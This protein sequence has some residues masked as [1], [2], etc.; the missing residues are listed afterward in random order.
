M[1]YDLIIIGGA[2]GSGK[3]TVQDIVA[4]KLSNV[5]ID[6]GN[7]REFHLDRYWKKANDK[8]ELMAF[9]N[10]VFIIKNYLKNK[11]INIMVNDLKYDKVIKLMRSFSKKKI[12]LIILTSEENELKKRIT[13]P[14]NSGFKNVKKALEYN[15]QWKDCNLKNSIKIDNSHNN[16]KKTAQKII[17][18]IN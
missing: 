5:C 1:A 7:L 18:I 11:Y 12:I 14:R 2:P 17:S 15:K 8:E 13:S 9:Q 3:S 10:L 6:F 16:P 4:K